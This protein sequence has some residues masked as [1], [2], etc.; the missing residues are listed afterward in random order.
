MEHI[1]RDAPRMVEEFAKEEQ[2]GIKKIVPSILRKGIENLNLS[3]FDEETKRKLLNATGEELMKK[4]DMLEAEKAFVLTDN[5]EKLIEIGDGFIKVGM[6]SQAI[7]A[8]K[9]ANSK[10]K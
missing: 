9:M 4:G 10:E 3:M 7:D 6:F 1:K 8:F 5:K 2:S